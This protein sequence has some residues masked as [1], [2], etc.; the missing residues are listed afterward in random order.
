MAVSLVG[1]ERIDIGPSLF[2][3]STVSEESVPSL[4]KYKLNVSKDPEAASAIKN[5]LVTAVVEAGND[6]RANR[7]VPSISLYSAVS[8]PV[9]GDVERLGPA[10]A[11]ISKIDLE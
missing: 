1:I 9:N 4:C 6:R 8:G 5:T 2:P 7:F 11:P 10:L 3:R